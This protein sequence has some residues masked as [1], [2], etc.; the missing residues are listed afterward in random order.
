MVAGLV[1]AQPRQA[2][3]VERLEQGDTVA[4][5]T[6]GT[7]LTGGRWAWPVVMKEWLE[8]EWPGILAGAL[9]WRSA[10]G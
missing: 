7:S 1:A 6:M 3:F 9:Q 4:I 10:P 2:H 5:V 8:A